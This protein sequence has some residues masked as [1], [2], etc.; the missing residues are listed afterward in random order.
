[1]NSLDQVL[2]RPRIQEDSVKD[3]CMHTPKGTFQAGSQGRQQRSSWGPGASCFWRSSKQGP[4]V[5][6]GTLPSMATRAQILQ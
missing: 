5:C 6:A 1:M 4:K 2:H 3:I